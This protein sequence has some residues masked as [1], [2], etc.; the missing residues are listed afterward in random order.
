MYG[1]PARARVEQF[2]PAHAAEQQA[3]VAQPQRGAAVEFEILQ[4]VVQP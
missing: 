1:C 3:S 2:R 4:A